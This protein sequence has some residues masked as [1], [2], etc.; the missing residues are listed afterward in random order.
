MS[1]IDE[2]LLI[3]S[4]CGCLIVSVRFIFFRLFFEDSEEV[5][6]Y[7]YESDDFVEIR[8]KISYLGEMDLLGE[9]FDIL[10]IYSLD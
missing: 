4:I 2:R 10:S 1:I 9:I 3:C 5:F 7:F 6:V 8:V